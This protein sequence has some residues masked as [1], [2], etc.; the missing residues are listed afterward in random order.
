MS[1]K[2][3]L[4]AMT[5]NGFSTEFRKIMADTDY[6]TFILKG[7]AGTGKS[8]LMKKI[9]AEFEPLEHVTRYYCSSD[10]ASLDAVVLHGSKAIICDG[11]A[12]HVMECTYPGACQKIVNLGQYWD[13]TKLKAHKNEIVDV[14][15]KN[16][17]MLARDRKSVV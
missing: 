16:Q 5:Q 13:E 8:S 7:G 2:Y 3:F 4:G 9:A 11:T 6:Y 14:T 10:P 12:P 15:D 1:E 17:S